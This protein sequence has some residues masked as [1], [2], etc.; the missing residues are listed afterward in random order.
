MKILII[1][2]TPKTE[3]V[4]YSFVQT[5]EATA[6]NLGV[7][8]ETI[9]LSK[10]NLT[11]CRMCKDGWGICF[12][13]HI[14]VF[15]EKDGFNALQEKVRDADA[16]I[17]ITPVYWGEISEEMKIFIDKLRRCQAT[18]QWD[19]RPEEVSYLKGKPSIVVANA[20]GGGGGIIST[21]QDLERAISQMDGDGWPREKAGLFDW[22]A[23]NRWNQSYKRDTL[24][25]AMTK[26]V[27]YNTLPG[28]KAVK[29]IDDYQ[30]EILFEDD[31]TRIFDMKPYIATPKF[32]ELEDVE[33]FNHVKITG[34]WIE[35]RP[36]LDIGIELI[37]KESV[38]KP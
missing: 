29:A 4:T 33:K 28:F 5:A 18:K 12:Q 36:L 30:L 7:E 32:K 13:Q 34:F 31:Q 14:C 35:W 21:F 24:T 23:V 1:S 6:Q 20:G 27:N 17:Y 25:A 15:G 37:Y 2:G 3:G 22:I 11:K 38:V 16:F 8:Y 9:T 19:A 10:Q 26:M